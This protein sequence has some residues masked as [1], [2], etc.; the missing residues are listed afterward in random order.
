MCTGRRRMS[1]VT[2]RRRRD[3]GCWRVCGGSAS[4]C[5]RLDPAGQETGDL[6]AAAWSPLGG[7]GE[8]GAGDGSRFDTGRQDEAETL[9]AGLA[10]TA[11]DKTEEARGALA[12][13]AQRMPPAVRPHPGG[14]GGTGRGEGTVKPRC[15]RIL[16]TGKACALRVGHP[17]VCNSYVRPNK[18]GRTIRN[19][20]PDGIRRSSME[21]MHGPEWPEW[22]ARTWQAQDGRCFLC[23][24]ELTGKTR[25]MH[26]D[27][28]HRCCPQN[29]SCRRCRRGLSCRRCNQLIG[30]VF[31][32]PDLLRRIAD[33][34]E[35]LPPLAPR[36]ALQDPLALASA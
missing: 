12:C 36:E 30:L 22:Y 27:H 16:R 5:A 6:P 23:G 35:R 31:E 14:G 20:S 26:T 15:G 32:D 17:Q 29:R 19:R 3:L 4:G 33:T 13:R 25:E 18:T 34:L 11:S 9:T 21:V 10:R 8:P 1:A 7:G 28:D 24:N 2:R